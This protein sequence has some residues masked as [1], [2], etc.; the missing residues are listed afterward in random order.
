MPAAAPGLLKIL[1]SWPHPEGEP[2]GCARGR[3]NERLNRF[4][5]YVVKT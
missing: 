4:Y 1:Y 2:V 3:I 5:H